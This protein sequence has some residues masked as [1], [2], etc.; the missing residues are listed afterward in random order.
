MAKEFLAV[1]AT[2]AACERLFSEGRRVINYWRSRLMAESVEELMMLKS[3]YSND[4]LRA[5]ENKDSDEEDGPFNI[6]L[7]APTEQECWSSSYGRFSSFNHRQKI[8][9]GQE[10]ES[11]FYS[12]KYPAR[13]L[14]GILKVLVCRGTSI[15]KRVIFLK[16]VSYSSK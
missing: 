15:L 3:W 4:N 13:N 6:S 7:N 8:V 2:S 1:Q 11:W 10:A 5:Y 12:S 14:I 16:N 9:L